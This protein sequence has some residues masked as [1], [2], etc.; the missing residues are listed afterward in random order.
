MTGLGARLSRLPADTMATLSFF[1]RLP[2]DAPPGSFGLHQSAG[3]WPLSG[4]V[5]AIIPALLFWLA[6]A[7]HLPSMLA[8][9]LALAALVLITGAM[10]E[11][12]L[13]DTADGLAGGSSRD[14]KLEIMRD[15][16]LGTFGALALLFSVLIRAGALAAILYA[17]VVSAAI[18]ILMAAVISRSMALWHWN[19]TLP[20]RADGM[21]RA[22]GRPD[23]LALAIG[24]GAGAIAA[25]V[26]VFLFGLPGL[27]GV[28]VAALATGIFTGVCVR[29]I[30]GHTG[31][32]I[33]AA[34]QIAETALLL[35][36]TIRLT[37]LAD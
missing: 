17:G 33:G 27:T 10:H 35:G 12:G 21:A 30:G 14:R 19:A 13:A 25:L 5:V 11:D 16:R 15:S 23:W 20:A 28:L 9:L 22:A 29:Q 24:L 4:L 2:V 18:A 7:A 34:Q 37:N 32:T 36:L 31:D 26:L 3:A 8:A 1:S 6:V